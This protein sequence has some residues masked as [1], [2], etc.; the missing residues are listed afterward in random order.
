MATLVTSRG[1]HARHL[2]RAATHRA[3][4]AYLLSLKGL[5]RGDFGPACATRLC[6][7][8]ARERDALRDALMAAKGERTYWTAPRSAFPLTY[9]LP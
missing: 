8:V 1:F 3:H 9:R 5:A 6:E 2:A 4:L 7:C